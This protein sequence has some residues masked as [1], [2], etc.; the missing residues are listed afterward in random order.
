MI[1]TPP[2]RTVLRGYDPDQVSAALADLTSSLA[3]ARRTAADRTMELTK[4][5]EREAALSADLDEAVARLTATEGSG[6]RSQDLGEVG[7]RVS[8]I[9]H[10]ADEEAGQIRADGER[11]ASQVRETAEADAT[12]MKA[13]ATAT[14]DA[15]VQQ[16]NEDAATTRRAEAATRARVAD[17]ERRAAD[18]VESARRGAVS[19]GRRVQAEYAQAGRARDE[20]HTQLSGVLVLLDSLDVELGRDPGQLPSSG[21]TGLGEESVVETGDG[22]R[23]DA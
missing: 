15:I 6:G 2:F 8:S 7:A 16:A 5:H 23:Q 20:I 22:A 17:A 14:A 3:I 1:E 19:E 13:A 4:A 21:A 11:Y 9:L 12:R 18:I 10:L